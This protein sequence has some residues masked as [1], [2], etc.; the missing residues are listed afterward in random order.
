MTLAD[1]WDAEISTARVIRKLREADIQKKCVAYAR[2]KGY[3]ARKFSS[4]A[5]R[6]V[7]DFLFGK[8]WSSGEVHWAEEFK[9]PREHPTDAQLEEQ[10]L[11]IAAGWTVYR[12]TG[13]NGQADIDRFERRIDD[14]EQRYR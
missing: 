5:N 10:D 12:E 14:L 13:T 7:P 9:A 6:S 11:M 4:P 8:A 2:S 1:P 3:W